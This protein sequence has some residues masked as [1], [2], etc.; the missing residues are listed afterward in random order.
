MWSSDTF[1][2]ASMGPAPAVFVLPQTN[3]VTFRICPTIMIE[4]Q[5]NSA[6]P[7]NVATATV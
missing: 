5:T 7:S 6:P 3:P 4:L 1:P 2:F